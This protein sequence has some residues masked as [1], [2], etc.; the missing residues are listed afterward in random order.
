M[1]FVLFVLLTLKEN[2]RMYLSTYVNITFQLMY[3]EIHHGNIHVSNYR[4]GIYE[5]DNV[6]KMY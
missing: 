3:V 4:T 2:S 1:T 5:A 6:L